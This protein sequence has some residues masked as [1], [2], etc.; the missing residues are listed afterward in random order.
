MNAS[1]VL[2][3]GNSTVL[4]AIDGL[5]EPDWRVG[6]VCGRWSVREILAHLA[7]Y[8]CVLVDILHSLVDDDA[9]PHLD[10]Y[11]EQGMAFNDLQVE[12][13]KTMT[14]GEVLAEYT[15]AHAQT[16]G[17]IERI[18]E[19]SRRRAG[20]LPWYGMEYDLE[21]FIAYAYYGHK[22][23]HCAQIGVFRDGLT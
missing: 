15:A 22:R 5:A 19:A 1:D 16:M 3:Y 4:Q 12:H 20:V 13:R 18:P 21:D 9:T 11:L 17:L 23:E 8:E 6:G 10:Q 7:S 14:S 2:K